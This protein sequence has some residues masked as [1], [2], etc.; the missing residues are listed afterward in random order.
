MLSKSTG[1]SI[2]KRAGVRQI[3]AVVSIVAVAGMSAAPL[4]AETGEAEISKTKTPKLCEML[5]AFDTALQRRFYEANYAPATFG[6]SFIDGKGCDFDAPQRI[7]IR[8]THAKDMGCTASGDCRFHAR[9]EC[10]GDVRT[11]LS[12]QTLM[13]KF[14]DSYEVSGRFTATA[15]AKS[16][17]RLEGWRRSPAPEVSTADAKISKLCPALAR[18]E[19]DKSGTSL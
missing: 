3:F 9:Q 12:C 14:E 11:M 6:C 5:S 10:V 15:D 4:L 19:S 17:W 8:V 1:G 13:Y 16:G 18:D 7:T 2:L